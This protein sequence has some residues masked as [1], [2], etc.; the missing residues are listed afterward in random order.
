PLL[1][2]HE[3]IFQYLQKMNGIYFIPIFS[4][5]VCGMLFKRIPPIAAKI[6]LLLGII[7]IVCGYFISPFTSWVSSIH[8]FHFLGMV[9][10]L[11]V[12]I[13]LAFG[14]FK[15][16]LDVRSENVESLVDMT[17]W[18]KVNYM[19]IFLC[20]VVLMLYFVFADFSVL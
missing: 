13:L 17:P 4:V 10:L 15:P 1:M 19:G 12:S 3:S 2:R 20:V 7:I 14:K 16:L 11:L 18:S 6:S 8:E 9:F 5:V